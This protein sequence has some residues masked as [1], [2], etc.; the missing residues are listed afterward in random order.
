MNVITRTAKRVKLKSTL[1]TVK[2]EVILVATAKRHQSPAESTQVDSEDEFIDSELKFDC[3]PVSIT[4]SEV[5]IN[6]KKFFASITSK[7]NPIQAECE[8]ESITS[9]LHLGGHDQRY[10][11]NIDGEAKCRSQRLR[12]LPLAMAADLKVIVT[13]SAARV[14][15][16]LPV[17]E[18]STTTPQRIAIAKTDSQPAPATTLSYV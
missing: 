7:T 10:R 12:T 9:S 15:A 13:H 16:G 11:S 14:I 3:L 4:S 1:P 6:I 5:P 8:S 18:E 2:K 17:F